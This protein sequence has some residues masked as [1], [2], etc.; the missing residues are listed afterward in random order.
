[1]IS[2]SKVQ[3]YLNAYSKQEGFSIF[4]DTN[5]SGEQATYLFLEPI[6]RAY[7]I[8][9]IAAIETASSTVH[10]SSPFD[11]L[12]HL[13]GIA[14]S[15]SAS[16]NQ[17]P[18]VAGFLGYEFLHQIESIPRRSRLSQTPDALFYIYRKTIAISKSG[19]IAQSLFSHPELDNTPFW[20]TSGEPPPNI[21]K[22]DLTSHP[23]VKMQL[24]PTQ[25]LDFT[26]ESYIST[27]EEVKRGI[28]NGDFYQINLSRRVTYPLISSTEQ[29]F[30]E[31]CQTSPAD[32]AAYIFGGAGECW[33]PFTVM[34]AS[35]ELFLRKDGRHL[36]SSPIKGTRPRGHSAKEDL[37]SRDELLASEKDRAELAMIVDLVRNDLGRVA[38]SNSVTVLHHARLTSLPQVH[39]LVSDIRCTIR[40]N[41]SFS[42]IIRSLFPAGSITGTPKI[43]AM[44]YLAQ[45]ECSNRGVYTGSIGCLSPNGN[46]CFNVAIRTGVVSNNSLTL[47]SGGGIT[48]ESDSESEYQETLDKL[49]P[50]AGVTHPPLAAPELKQ[51]DTASIRSNISFST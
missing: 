7:L 49:A 14:A 51:L 30:L 26:K 9:Q 34:S 36:F 8:D 44:Q 13:A 15:G 38:Q 43:A 46:F 35:P 31:L 23:E 21:S 11:L 1:M 45:H 47:G 5:S 32:F 28:L 20:L 39:H 22:L 29:F 19:E 37:R 24:A 3:P 33:D 18:C 2:I 41:V 10:Y 12:D 50:F 48:L 16:T 42:E 4:S 17:I 27:I 6:A 40:D 25:L